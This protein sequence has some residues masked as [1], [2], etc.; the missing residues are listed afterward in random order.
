MHLVVLGLNHKTAPVDLRECYAFSEEK[1]KKTLRYL[2]EY[3]SEL[4][5][6]LFC[7]PATAAKCTQWWMKPM[8]RYRC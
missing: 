3:I 2:Q 5:N 1:V 6:V 7:R 4:T 8:K